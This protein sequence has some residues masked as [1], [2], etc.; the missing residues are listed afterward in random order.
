MTKNKNR[1]LTLVAAGA[2]A[3]G[4]LLFASSR[5]SAVDCSHA[6]IRT[7]D[8]LDA[9]TDS[10]SDQGCRDSCNGKANWSKQNGCWIN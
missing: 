4:G 9:C 3:V 1:I 8:Q 6:S 2:I 7:E 5:A 10:C